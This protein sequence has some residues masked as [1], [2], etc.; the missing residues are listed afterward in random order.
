[1]TATPPPLPDMRQPAALR[2]HVKSILDFYDPRA[3]DPSGGFFQFFKDDGTV[4]NRVRRHL[5]S[6][7]RYVFLWS[8]A[9]RRFPDQPQYLDYARR[10][11]AFLHEAHR[12]PAGNY[13]WELDWVDGRAQ[14]VDATQH[15]YGLAFV[16]LAHAHAAMAG[17]DEARAGMAET[18]ATIDAR[19][20]QPAHGLVADEISPAGELLPYR[21]QNANMHLVEACLAA[22]EASGDDI[23][24]DRAATVAHSVVQRLTVPSDG[25]IWEH[26]TPDWQIDWEYNKG[27]ATNIF[28]PWGYQPGHFT[29]WGQ[30]LLLLEQRRPEP[31]HLPRARALFDAALKHGWD[32]TH[33]GIVYGFGPG[34]VVCF[35]DKYHWV[36]CESLA[37]AALLGARTGEARYWQVYDQLWDYAWRHWV[38]HEHGAWFRILGPDNVKHTNEKSPAGKVD[39]HT[40]GACWRAMQV[41]EGLGKAARPA[42]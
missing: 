26:Y 4:Y 20:W 25:W 33:G 19:F 42:G 5:V 6:S 2:A 30:L 8:M 10:A 29:E 17:I 39:Y 31:W 37:T 15:A 41:L 11:L 28:R 13:L 32:Q 3:V 23:Y 18:L 34:G 1:M 21:G 38:D 12:Q 22:H 7:T 40:T 36:Q 9:A 35:P 16:L 24:L 14:R 27:D